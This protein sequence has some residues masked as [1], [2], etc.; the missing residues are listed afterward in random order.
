MST[1]PTTIGDLRESQTGR[2]I[3]VHDRD[4]TIT[5]PFTG[6]HV[7]QDWIEDLTAA[8]PEPQRVPGRKTITVSVGRWTS[9]DL[10]PST[11]VTL[12][13]EA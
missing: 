11:V 7:D 1:E 6:L 3:T 2:T 13:G 5:G 8:D 12:H 9:G 4:V 10:A